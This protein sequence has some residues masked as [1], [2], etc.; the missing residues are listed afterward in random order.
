MHRLQLYAYDRRIIWCKPCAISLWRPRTHPWFREISKKF[1]DN[2]KKFPD[3]WHRHPSTIH[4]TYPPPKTSTPFSS[5]FR[6]STILPVFL[7]PSNIINS[8][9]ITHILTWCIVWGIV[10]EKSIISWE[11]NIFLTFW[12]RF[13]IETWTFWNNYRIN[14]YI[15]LGW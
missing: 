12:T 10:T 6:Y 4:L 15:I 5:R 1:R 13:K 14:I 8:L 2:Y 9:T 11:I 3:S 7:P